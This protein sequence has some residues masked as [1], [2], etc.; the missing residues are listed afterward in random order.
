[1]RTWRPIAG[2]GLGAGHSSGRLN[3]A[4]GLMKRVVI[5]IALA[6]GV[7]VP[8]IA[9]ARVRLPQPIYFW[10]STTAAVSVPKGQGPTPNSRVIRPSVIVMFADGSW[11][12][13]HLHWSGWG[14]SAA[15]ATGVSDASNG[16]PSQAGGKRI[17]RPA[18]VTL[19][20]PGRFQGREV[21][22]CF[23]LMVPAYPPSDQS[24]CLTRVRGYYYLGSTALHLADFLSPDRKVWCGISGSPAFCV[25]GPTTARSNPAQRSG[26]LDSSGKVTLCFVA[27]P[28]FGH[29][30]T[31]NWDSNAPVLRYGRQ[32]ELNGFRCS[33]APSGITCIVMA[34]KGAGKGFVI[35]STSVRRVG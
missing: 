10:G 25:T 3:R 13:N 17:R 26:T 19:S 7:T 2:H 5:A 20:N 22:R 32:T 34:G 14:S 30:C 1:V 21:Y 4:T 16:M 23:T 29:A 11:Y 6:V 31:Q 35:T 9:E 24:L 8:A 12:I 18:R 15:H 28:R 33:S 27:V